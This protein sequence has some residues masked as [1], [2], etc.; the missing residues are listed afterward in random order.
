MLKIARCII[1]KAQNSALPP[2]M[3]AKFSLHLLVSKKGIL[4]T[5]I[6]HKAS[7]WY[8]LA[9]QGAQNT[10]ETASWYRCNESNNGYYKRAYY[11]LARTKV[12]C[13]AIIALTGHND[14]CDND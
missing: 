5:I 7:E 12:T 11:E 13:T 4:F 8:K 1:N 3:L 9:M 6:G 14:P 10:V 2:A